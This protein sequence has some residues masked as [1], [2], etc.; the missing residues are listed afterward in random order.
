MAEFYSATVRLFD[1]FYGPVLLRDSH[2]FAVVLDQL[3][4]ADRGVVMP[5]SVHMTPPNSNKLK[6]TK[7]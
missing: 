6:N 4:L 5:T 7:G 2:G 3:Q 1:R